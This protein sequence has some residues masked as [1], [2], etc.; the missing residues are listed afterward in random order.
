MNSTMSRIVASGLVAGCLLALSGCKPSSTEGAA[1]EA[2]EVDV[3]P[4][5][6]KE[7]LQRSLYNGQ[8]AAINAVE[9]QARVTGQVVKVA[10]QEG[11][12]VAKGDLLFVID[13]RPY[14]IAV[15]NA[16]AQLDRAVVAQ[17]LAR[18][19]DQRAKALLADRATSKEEAEERAS[20]YAQ[21]SAEVNAADAALKAAQLNLQFT[22]VRAPVAGRTS[23]AEVTLGNMAVADQ[24]VLTS[25]VS[26]DPVY[27]YFNPDEQ[28]FIRMKSALQPGE[29]SLGNELRI[30]RAGEEDLPY[31]GKIDLVDNRVDSSTGTIRVRAV[32]PNASD[33]L[34]PGMFANV[35]LGMPSKGPVVLITDR[36]ILTD[37][38]KKYVYVVGRDRKANRR[39]VQVGNLSGDGL[40]IIDR[41]LTE[42]DQVVVAGL[43]KI[44]ASDTLVRP[45][46]VSMV[47]PANAV[48]TNSTPGQ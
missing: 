35:Q 33:L 45:R 6:H 21:A 10:F 17:T 48:P 2:P 29:A 5:M 25:V 12:L 4:V 19:Q 44:Y 34:T 13:Q 32:V 7:V 23:R 16:R 28:D 11:G 24:T 3:A 1:A 46:M 40:R 43:Q 15:Q 39:E 14:Q 36:A 41:G 42:A 9:I 20:S 37:Q 18:Q 26:Q 27:V 47:K 8:V 38:D 30:G 31:V 22:E